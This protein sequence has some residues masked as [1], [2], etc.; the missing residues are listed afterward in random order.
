MD[1]INLLVYIL[2][3]GCVVWLA[4]W[5]IGQAFPQPIQMVAKI[6]V[7]VIALIVLLGYFLGTGS[8]IHLAPLAR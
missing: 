1:L 3:F 4:F 8:G 7:G 2:I 6:V 5:V